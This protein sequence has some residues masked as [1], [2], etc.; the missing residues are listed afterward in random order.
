RAARAKLLG[1]ASHAHWILDDNMARTPEAAMAL[2][3]KVWRP[4]V[5]RVREEVADMQ[6]IADAEQAGHAIAPWDYRYYA[7]NVRKAKY[8]L[9]EG[10]VKAYLQ[11]ERMRE[12]MFWAA[13]QLYGMKFTL[14][15]GVPTYHPEAEVYEVTRG[16]ER[17][18]LWYFDAYARDG[19]HSGAWMS[20]YRT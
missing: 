6:Q 5:A 20:E 8:A 3:M 12:A 14:L 9:D 4:A 19:K 13:E 7:E 10:E 16:S 18:G 15:Q 11:L 17:V 1:H 2:L